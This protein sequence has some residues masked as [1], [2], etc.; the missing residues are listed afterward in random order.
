MPGHSEDRKA[1]ADCAPMIGNPVNTACV[2]GSSLI[3]ALTAGG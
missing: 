1:A 2:T 3:D